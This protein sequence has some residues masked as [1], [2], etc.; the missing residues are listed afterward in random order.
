[1]QGM[2]ELMEERRYFVKGKQGRYIS[3]WAGKI[4]YNRNMRAIHCPA[5]PVL[6]LIRG[7]PGAGT[8]TGTWMPVGIQQCFVLP[9][10]QYF[11]YGYLVM[12]GWY[13]IALSKLQTVKLACC[14]KSCV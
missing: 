1:M 6:S 10:F 2:A 12:I 14:I 3:G 9:V 11:I 5:I 8:F 4:T 13:V 7:H